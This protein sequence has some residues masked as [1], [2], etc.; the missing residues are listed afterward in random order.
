MLSIRLYPL[1]YLILDER[2]SFNLEINNVMEEYW[3]EILF[4]SYEF[5]DFL[6]LV[7]LCEPAINFV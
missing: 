5:K 4:S 6:H 1:K 7:H 2:G 3:K